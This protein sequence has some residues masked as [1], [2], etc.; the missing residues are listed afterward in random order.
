MYSFAQT[1]RSIDLHSGK[2]HYTGWTW[3]DQVTSRSC[4][5]YHH[6]HL[7]IIS[8]Y[9]LQMVAIC[10]NLVMN[11]DDQSRCWQWLRYA[12]ILFSR[13]ASKHTLT[14]NGRFL[15]SNF[16]VS[17]SPYWVSAYSDKRLPCFC[18][19][20][21]APVLAKKYQGGAL[22]SGHGHGNATW[23]PQGVELIFCRSKS[24]RRFLGRVPCHSSRNTLKLLS[25]KYFD[26][27]TVLVI[28]VLSCK[29]A[30]LC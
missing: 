10:Y 24:G 11:C 4:H 22:Q 27:S 6:D 9:R 14:G 18:L 29:K 13:R 2:G 17:D 20:M 12:K 7:R 26:A 21:D 25:L 3:L 8:H 5:H 1:A 16:S 30:C 19:Q 28:I 23:Q 15:H